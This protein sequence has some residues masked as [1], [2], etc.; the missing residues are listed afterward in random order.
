MS[1]PRRHASRIPWL[2]PLFEPPTTGGFLLPCLKDTS[3]K[4]PGGDTR[5]LDEASGR[6]SS[7]PREVDFSREH[8]KEVRANAEPLSR[9]SGSYDWLYVYDERHC[10]L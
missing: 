2:V 1:L 4:V 10:G 7:P 9:K 5:R 6:G 8:T 3:L